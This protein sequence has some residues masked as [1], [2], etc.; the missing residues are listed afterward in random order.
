MNWIKSIIGSV[1]L[2]IGVLFSVSGQEETDSLF[3]D[4]NFDSISQTQFE[5]MRLAYFQKMAKKTD[6]TTSFGA[7]GVIEETNCDQICET[8][9]IDTLSG[10]RMWLPSNYDQGILGSDFSPFKNQFMVYSSYDGPDFE[11]YYDYRAELFV[12]TILDATGLEA[13]KMQLNYYTTDFSISEI[14]W[15]GENEIALKIYEESRWGDG[16]HLEFKYLKTILE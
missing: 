6:F 7:L 2:C 11:N 1:F 4:L 14:I 13:L 10:K 3:L 12:Y 16:S 5:S 8:Y 9:L 15:I